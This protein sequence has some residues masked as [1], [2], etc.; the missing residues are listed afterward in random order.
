[1][2]YSYFGT[3]FNKSCPWFGGF[4]IFNCLVS[5]IFNCSL[6]ISPIF[7]YWWCI[8]MSFFVAV[9]GCLEHVQ[10]SCHESDLDRVPQNWR[11]K[12]SVTLCPCSSLLC[13]V[14]CSSVRHSCCR[15]HWASSSQS[16]I[17]LLTICTWKRRLR[18]PIATFQ[19]LRALETSLSSTRT[20]NKM[21]IFTIHVF[22]WLIKM[23]S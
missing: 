13:C 18:Y 4:D 12:W 5:N 17:I 7:T 19:S 15:G 14:W 9:P 1:M 2:Y 8:V 3:K 20:A 23:V 21:W 16:R 10:W 22:T 6:I 11:Q